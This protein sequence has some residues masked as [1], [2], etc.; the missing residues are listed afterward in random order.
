MPPA[1][2]ALLLLLPAL[3]AAADTDRMLLQGGRV[4]S[5]TLQAADEATLTLQ[6]RWSP[7]ASIP[8]P[9][10]ELHFLRR[11]SPGK[12]QRFSASAWL[13]RLHHGD[14]LNASALEMQEGILLAT[15]PELGEL[16][17]PRAQ[18][19]QLIYRPHLPQVLLWEPPP[20]D[21]WIFQHHHAAP[22]EM[23]HAARGWIARGAGNH[24]LEISHWPDLFVLQLE[25]QVQTH[26]Q[27][28]ISHQASHANLNQS[29]NP[30][31]TLYANRV[32]AVAPRPN[33]RHPTHIM[34]QTIWQEGVQQGLGRTV[35]LELFV[36]QNKGDHFLVL[37]GELFKSWNEKGP[38]R[39]ADAD[40]PSWLVIANQNQQ[41]FQIS[42]LRLQEWD[43]IPPTPHP[44]RPA[45]ERD[46]LQL[47][48]GER[49]IGEV[50]AID[51]DHLHLRQP[52]GGTR[53]IPLDTLRE[54][55]LA[56][57]PL[58]GQSPNRFRLSLQ[59]G[60]T[61]L[62]LSSFS[63]EGTEA[64]VTSPNLSHPVQIPMSRLHLL[65]SLQ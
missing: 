23:V 20:P 62:T 58:P 45:G 4:I 50:T 63:V 28:Q 14:S 10:D 55:A 60:E 16:R 44:L 18:V 27:L 13:L 64:R 37:N 35:S 21:Q 51:A 36:D 49:V 56:H 39:D 19:L 3:N 52:G 8:F 24:A 9:A 30:V 33:P 5:G 25:L 22:P 46:H 11:I 2:L 53:L 57:L 1:L 42:H 17:I 32:Q 41:S 26:L 34:R 7:G 48:N 31:L 59:G 43:G 54:A 38:K 12:D 61:V 29:Q 47:R 6:P 40:V 15:H 65:E